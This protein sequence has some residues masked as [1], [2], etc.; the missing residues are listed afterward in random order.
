MRAT[1]LIKEIEHMSY[2][3]RLKYLNLPTLSYR[4]LRGDI[5]MMYKLLSGIYDLNIAYHVVKPNNY[6]SR[7][8]HLQLF[9]RHVHH[10]LRKFYFG[11]RII[12]IWN[13]LP[14]YVTNANSIGLFESSLERFWSNQACLFDYKADLA[15]TGSRSQT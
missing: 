2:I 6:V 15:G 13:S 14:N 11:N 10:D 3:V 12:S 9:K 4:R 1:K 7:G 5:I 8:H